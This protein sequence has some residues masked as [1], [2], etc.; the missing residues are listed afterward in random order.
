M[1]V[2]ETKTTSPAGLP[3]ATFNRILEEGYGPGAWYGSDLRAAVG[4]V[5]AA[6]AFTRPARAA[7]TS[8]KSRSTTPT[9][10]GRLPASSPGRRRRR[11]RWRA[12]IG[13]T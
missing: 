9:G 11:S 5:T 2:I 13:S 7:T 8:P 1:S 3:A 10:R 6:T 4:D 12:R